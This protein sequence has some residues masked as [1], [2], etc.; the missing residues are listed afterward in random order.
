MGVPNIE[1][2]SDIG[3]LIAH[4]PTKDNNLYQALLRLRNALISVNNAIVDFDGS[5][6]LGEQAY[7]THPTRVR[8]DDTI[9]R[10]VSDILGDTPSVFSWFPDQATIAAV[11]DGTGADVGEYIQAAIDGIS[12]TGGGTLV[13]PRGVYKIGTIGDTAIGLQ[14]RSGVRL[15]GSSIGATLLQYQGDGSAILIQSCQGV[16]LENLYIFCTSVEDTV[17]GIHFRNDSGDNLRNNITR[18]KIW[19]TRSL[20]DGPTGDLVDTNSDGLNTCVTN[21]YDDGLRDGMFATRHDTSTPANNGLTGLVILQRDPVTDDPTGN[22]FSAG[23]ASTGGYYTSQYFVLHGKGIYFDDTEVEAMYFN[24]I[25]QCFVAFFAV[26]I[27]L[28]GNDTLN[29]PNANFFLSNETSAC[30]E[31]FVFRRYV[32]N[33][34]MSGHFCNGGGMGYPDQTGLVMGNDVEFLGAYNHH[35][36]GIHC[37]M[38]RRA[39]AYNIRSNTRYNYIAIDDQ[40][41]LPSV[42]LG[43]GNVILHTAGGRTQTTNPKIDMDVV[44]EDVTGAAFNTV[45]FKMRKSP[46]QSSNLIEVNDSIE[47]GDGTPKSMWRMSMWGEF[48]M[49]GLYNAASL[50]LSVQGLGWIG[51]GFPLNFDDTWIGYNTKFVAGQDNPTDPAFG[52]DVIRQRD[53][54]WLG[55]AAALRLGFGGL[56]QFY[57]ETDA[58]GEATAA[59]IAIVDGVVESTAHGLPVGATITITGN[60]NPSFNTGVRYR[61]LDVPDADH[62]DIGVDGSGTGGAWHWAIDKPMDPQPLPKV[63][64]HPDG[65]RIDY[66]NAVA[67]EPAF[68]VVNMDT[69]TLV[70]EVHGD[71]TTLNNTISL[72]TF[73]T[74]PNGSVTASVG[75]VCF[76]SDGTLWTKTS[77][78]PSN[79]G[80]VVLAT[81]SAIAGAYVNLTTNQSIAGVK[82]FANGITLGGGA[83]LTSKS[84]SVGVDGPVVIGGLTINFSG[85][86]YIGV[87]G[88]VGGNY[89]G[90][91]VISGLTI[92]FTSGMVTGTSGTY[93]P[94]SGAVASVFGRTGAVVKVAGDY[95][96]ADIGSIIAHAQMPTTV[97]AHTVPL[98]KL[99]GGGANG[100]LQF[101]A[102]GILINWADPT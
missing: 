71:H 24:E 78:S 81:S 46:D 54:E 56:I 86:V 14:M 44:N 93:V 90:S 37:D 75:D 33:C 48:I 68:S 89:T 25:Q 5:G 31:H 74:D 38:G 11:S 40:C 99:T 47:F 30:A 3:A 64:I 62:F 45:E 70:F 80:W 102:Q 55:G 10:Y 77:G 35:L 63:V 59:I 88:T 32:G 61:V 6:L 51:S 29:T 36:Y 4:L 18:C 20:V 98:A 73:N 17:V 85:G 22:F 97:V 2:Q 95:N 84:G 13:L 83:V 39:A 100:S 50:W 60:S 1:K 23:S 101:N 91:V 72:F 76:V 27:Q 42:N 92:T 69:S 12:S 8:W 28:E 53:A 15:Q 66:Y 34:N 43:T 67:I 79:T 16:S 21:C 57:A 52:D 26:G 94:P 9:P 87:S 96:F 41:S 19:G 49:S 7:I 65:I 82:T 58:T